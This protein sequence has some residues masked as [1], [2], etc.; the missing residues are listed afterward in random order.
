[1]RPLEKLIGKKV[2]MVEMVDDNTTI[3]LNLDDGT[4]LLIGVHEE[5][6]WDG[7]KEGSYN[8]FFV[9]V[10]REYIV[11]LGGAEMRPL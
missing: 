5:E 3:R 8:R 4:V 6:E 11:W 10:D 9:Q 1:M 7:E 2:L